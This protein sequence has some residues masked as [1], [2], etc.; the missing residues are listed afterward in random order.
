VAE[1]DGLTFT[2]LAPLVESEG[3]TFT[4]LAPL[5]EGNRLTFAALAPLVVSGGLT[6]TPL[7]PL[8]VSGGLAFTPLAEG[9]RL[10]F[11]ALAEANAAEVA[12]LAEGDELNG[13]LSLSLMRLGPQD[14][15]KLKREALANEATAP[16][17]SEWLDASTSEWLDASASVA[18]SRRARV[19]ALTE[20]T[21]CK[22]RRLLR[23][24]IEN[25]TDRKRR[26]G[27]VSTTV[28]RSC[29]DCGVA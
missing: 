5:A 10:T 20:A 14:D 18:C 16:V 8:V 4:P 23:G 7:A 25:R 9:N 26:V 17:I 3:L 29:V 13:L 24:G 22:I 6:F 15:A 11:A 2:P 12:P 21:D 19:L 27:K 1:S 28:T